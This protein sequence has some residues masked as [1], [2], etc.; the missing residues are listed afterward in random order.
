MSVTTSRKH[1]GINPLHLV[2]GLLA[3]AVSIPAFAQS[4]PY[5]TYV[6][7]ANQN[8]TQGPGYPLTTTY[9]WVASDGAFLTP[10]G[11]Q[12]YLGITTR[13]KAV[14]LNPNTA[15]HTAAVLQMGGPQAVTIFNTQTG[16]VLQ[17]YSTQKGTNSDGSHNGIS[18]TPDGLH[19]LFSQDGNYGPSSYVAVANVDPVTGMLS[20]GTQVNVPM[21]VNALGALT[22]VTCFSREQ[23]SGNLRQL[24]HSVRLPGFDFLG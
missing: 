16:K 10:A 20:D 21:D 12:V 11:T 1:S 22:T 19:L 13:A 9:P 14:A 24:C 2:V 17:A 7:G 4:D 18:Y 8:G 15:T 6:V 3:A 23:P 5:P